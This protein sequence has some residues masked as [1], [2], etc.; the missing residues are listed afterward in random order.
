[1]TGARIPRDMV[2]C[3]LSLAGDSLLLGYWVTELLGYCLVTGLVVG[4][5]GYWV[6]EL[7]GYC[8]SYHPT[9]KCGGIFMQ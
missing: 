3:P 9:P 4:L 8:L 7:L 2:K 5:L 6:T 1:M